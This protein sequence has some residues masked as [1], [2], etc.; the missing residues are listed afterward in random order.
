MSDAQDDSWL[1]GTEGALEALKEVADMPD[2]NYEYRSVSQAFDDSDYA[3]LVALAW[4]HQFEDDRVRFKRELRE[5]EQ[6]ISRRVRALLE[7]GR[8]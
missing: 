7:E 4:R 6:Y 1:E 8:G 2:V 3:T 5:L